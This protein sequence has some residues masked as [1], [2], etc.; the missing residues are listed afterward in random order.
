[1][2]K[3]PYQGKI[4]VSR[5]Y[6]QADEIRKN[7][8]DENEI[9]KI[10]CTT[11][12]WFEIK[13]RIKNG[14]RVSIAIIGETRLGKSTVGIHIAKECHEI[15]NKLKL[16]NN[17]PFTCF[18]ICRTPDE[19]MERVKQPE[20]EQTSMVIDEYDASDD[21]GVN[22][23]ID[24]AI[25]NNISSIQAARYIDMI[26]IAPT[27]VYDPNAAMLLTVIERDKPTRTVHCKLGYK[28]IDNNYNDFVPIGYVRLYVGE[29]I[30]NWLKIESIFLKHK[31]TKKEKQHII[32]QA[33][34]DFLIEYNIR[35]HEKFELMTKEKIYRPR[36]L[37]YAQ[38]IMNV[39]DELRIF[40]KDSR[41]LNRS[42]IRN[43]IELQCEKAGVPTSVL[44][45]EI[46][47]R[48]AEGILDTWKAYFLAIKKIKTIKNNMKKAETNPI[49]YNYPELKKELKEKETYTILLEN[50]A[51]VQTNR[52]QH[53]IDLEKK[54]KSI[55]D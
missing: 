22:I 49:K 5:L 8:T 42:I 26:T 23:S 3:K 28:I 53:H 10:D 34:K 17:K 13:D 38:P 20:V 45:D 47:I 1:M 50:L 48:K 7:V 19:F 41:L 46:F 55:L 54:Y 4:K 30:N 2:N 37:K 39:V 44:G 21:T 25:F 31:K 33:K 9:D 16:G 40:A 27:E 18:N 29:L 11:D 35:K 32:N 24:R 52:L 12:F 15:R 36:E 51:Q 6:K 43:F 14:K